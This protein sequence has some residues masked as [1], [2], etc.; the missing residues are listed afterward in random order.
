MKPH[1]DLILCDK[2]LAIVEKYEK[3][4]WYLYPII[5]SLPRKHG[6]V[7]DMFMECLLGQVGLFIDAGKSGQISRLHLADSG[8]A[9]LRFWLRLV[10]GK[11]VRNMTNHQCETA[12]VLIA[13]VGAMMGAWISSTRNKG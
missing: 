3:V 8:L 4:I 1:R 7:K 12:L 13:E 11:L 2:Q 10:N 9:N 6:K 5:Q